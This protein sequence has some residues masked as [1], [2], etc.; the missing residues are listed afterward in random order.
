MLL[1]FNIAVFFS[2]GLKTLQG[3]TA[4]AY[5]DSSRPFTPDQSSPDNLKQQ[6]TDMA[7]EFK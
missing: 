1:L 7:S 2:Y 3:Q 6:L 4:L 5:L